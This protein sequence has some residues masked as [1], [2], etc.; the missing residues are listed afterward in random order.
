MSRSSLTTLDR[1]HNLDRNPSDRHVPRAEILFGRLRRKLLLLLFS[2]L[3]QV[4]D[5]YANHQQWTYDGM[6]PML[7]ANGSPTFV[8]FNKGHTNGGFVKV[9]PEDF[10]SAALHPNNDEKKKK[11]S[12]RNTVTVD[13]VD[14]SLKKVEEA[15]GKLYM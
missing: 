11:L 6:P 5:T 15:G 9:E 14:E 10:L 4:L 2:C 7:D 13:S 3:I 12:V 8:M 1:L